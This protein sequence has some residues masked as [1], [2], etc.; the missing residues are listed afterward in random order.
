MLEVKKLVVGEL[1]TNCFIVKNQEY[2]VIID[3]GSNP[4]KILE[5]V[6]DLTVEAICLTHGHF[7]HI[8]AVDKLVS[9]LHV[10]VYISEDDKCMLLDERLNCSYM[11]A[12]PF[13][14]HSP[15][16]CYPANLLKLPHFEFQVMDVP[17]HTLGCVLLAAEHHLFTGDTLF[18]QGIGRTD[19]PHASNSQMVNSL[20]FI[21][22][23]TSDYIVYPG[24][25]ETSTLFEEFKNNPY[26]K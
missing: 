18:K 2:A 12:Q 9:E 24:H 4:K 7:D 20:N 23:L 22:T 6:K 8:K 14:I 25:G 16:K 13:T 19:L 26:L 11:I 10:P 21:Q 1:Q 15:I 3:P 17:G 5:E